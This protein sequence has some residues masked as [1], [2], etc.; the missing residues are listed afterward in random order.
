MW[1]SMNHGRHVAGIQEFILF[2]NQLN[3]AE[4]SLLTRLCGYGLICILKS[5]AL[6]YQIFPCFQYT[7]NY[8][9]TAYVCSLFGC[10]YLDSLVVDLLMIA[11]QMYGIYQPLVLQHWFLSVQ[12]S[13]L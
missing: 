12:Y 8:I 6:N 11:N 5:W 3:T 4:A 9:F 2:L 7:M 10:F 1:L 13:T